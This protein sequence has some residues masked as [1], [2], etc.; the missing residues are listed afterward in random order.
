MT[1][2]SVEAAVERATGETVL[3]HEPL[4]SLASDVYLATLSGSG[5]VVVKVPSIESG[6]LSSPR[7]LSL[8]HEQT[9]V[10]V[11]RVLAVQDETDP[12]FLVLEYVDGRHVDHPDEL[13]A[14]EVRAVARSF[15]GTLGALHEMTIP[16]ST[17]GRV[18]CDDDGLHT[19]EGFD[20]WRP[21]LADTMAINLDALEGLALGDLAAPV[22]AHLD[23]ALPTVPD[24][25]TP[26]LHY[27][28]CKVENVVLSTDSEGPLF[29]AVLDWE[30]LE[31][32]HWAYTLAFPEVSFARRQSV[33]P[34]EDVL[35]ALHEGYAD[36][37]GWGAVPLE[38]PWFD[39][40]RLAALVLRAAS[41]HWL[42][43]RDDWSGEQARELRAA[44][45][46]LL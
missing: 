15:G 14:R 33:L 36:V 2:S 21:R 16:V 30:A 17:F 41:P 26:A 42:P 45:E 22:R 44:I 31:T 4:D 10:P 25:T 40:Y 7:L 18:R 8:V 38:A 32:T 13:S 12:A 1:F 6:R 19:V 5:R 9:E 20:S 23:D 11:P 39:T 3:D 29:E 34:V 24:V 27:H 28:D 46:A 43:A 35:R 37:R